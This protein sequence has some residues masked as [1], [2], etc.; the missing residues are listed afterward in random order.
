M[1]CGAG[2]PT[3]VGVRLKPDSDELLIYIEGGGSC[4]TGLSC[5]TRPSAANMEGYGAAEFAEEEKLNSYALFDVR[6]GSVNPF[7]DM[8]MVMIP[9]CTGD[10]HMGTT[11]RQLDDA[12]VM[13]DTHFV[14]ALNMRQLLPRLKA[15]FP[16]VKR[17]WIAG[18]SAGAGGANI[19]YGAIRATFGV[20]AELI[21]DSILLSSDREEPDN[22]ALWGAQAV[23]PDCTS[24]GALYRYNRALDPSSRLAFISFRYDDTIAGGNG[25][26][27]DAFAARIDQLATSMEPDPNQ[28]AFIVR[29][30]KGDGARGV[31]H[32]VTTKAMQA[33]EMIAACQAFLS[34]MV[35]G[36]PWDNAT[37]P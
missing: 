4:A 15:T 20:R 24:T 11:V 25:L 14:G 17:V 26:D 30:G 22:Q 35:S 19:H 5:W 23:C 12:G 33:P 18:T 32:V 8:N 36:G 2:S 27:L 21:I 34:K 31:Q 29:N 7:K 16:Q 3:G 37:Y 13:R 1:R 28:A 6:A 10:V 9:Y